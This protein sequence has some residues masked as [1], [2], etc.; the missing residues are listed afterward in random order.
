MELNTKLFIEELMREVRNEIHSLWTEM[1]DN[2][3]TQ[4]ASIN[5]HAT[6]LATTMQQHEE[7]VAVLESAV[8]D[9]DKVFTTWKPEVEASF[10]TIKLELSK[11]NSFFTHEGKTLDTSSLGILP[12]GSTSSHSS[13]G[14]TAAD[15]NGHHVETTHRDIGSGVV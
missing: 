11:F 1:Q 7:R 4:E 6:E 12:G 14:F 5:N 15:P 10:S 2:F 3:M 9:T 13:P 8:V